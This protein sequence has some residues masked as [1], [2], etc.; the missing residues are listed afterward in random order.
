MPDLS[1]PSLKAGAARVRLEPPLGIAMA[2]YGGRTGK[3]A[4]IHDELA[5]QAVAIADGRT[6]LAICGVDLLAL[7]I[8]IADDV[9][10]RVAAQSDIAADAIIIGAT[11]THSGP[12]F[13]IFATPKPDAGAAIDRD[14]AW[15][16]AL[17]EKIAGAILEAN[18]RL[19]PASIRVAASRFTLGTNRR[20]PTPTGETRLAAN[21]AGIADPEVKAL[22]VY[23]ADGT[24]IAF[25]MNYPCHGVVLCE[26][27][28]LYSRDYAGFA[29]D[30]IERPG[31]A[32]G[33]DA[34]PTEG[35][36]PIAIFL[37]GATGN[38]DPRVRGSFETAENWGRTMGRA[39]FEALSKASKIEDPKIAARRIPL[40][41]RLKDVDAVLTT[42]RAY[43]EQ[44]ERSLKSHPGGEYRLR[45]L[46]AE[47][48][49]ARN[50]LQM[51]E[52]FNEM[53]RRDRRVNLDKRELATHLSLAR[54]GEIAIV[55]IPG[56]AFV[57]FG[58]ALKANPHFAHTFVVGYCND[59][60]GYIPTREAYP[61]GGYEV[62]SARVAPGA[63]EQIVA[64][65][66]AGLSELSGG[67][68]AAA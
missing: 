16:R 37:N 5:A 21:Y 30:E 36:A 11:H 28:L 38:I 20:L 9:C 53:N 13:N 4:G 51:I 66:L 64:C 67:R 63:G 60:I 55:G 33:R 32:A 41:L 15:E 34:R 1:R 59:L 49:R 17:P 46:E 44:T 6:K 61:Q 22:G 65:A 2:G 27:N 35:S 68:L 23:R 42:A 12:L 29:Q 52:I 19:E 43:A 48:E 14:V 45:R 31:A 39:A 54:I 8:R 10:A 47:H 7:G 58:L 3:A 56:E 57:E 25:V 62:D 24:P 26:D 40:A 50:A 18:R